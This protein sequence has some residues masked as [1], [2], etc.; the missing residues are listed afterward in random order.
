VNTKRQ[1]QQ[2]GCEDNMDMTSDLWH[3]TARR[4][5]LQAHRNKRKKREIYHTNIRG[6]EGVGDVRMSTSTLRQR[7]RKI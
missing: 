1:R 3:R 2:G 4:E 7:H 6:G 5:R